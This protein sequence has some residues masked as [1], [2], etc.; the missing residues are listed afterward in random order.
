MPVRSIRK[1]NLN[2]TFEFAVP[3]A[4]GDLS[5]LVNQN[6]FSSPAGRVAIEGLAS[7]ANDIC[8]IV[9]TD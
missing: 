3:K 1:Q 7:R 4:S 9:Q 5:R 2:L 8:W 6:K